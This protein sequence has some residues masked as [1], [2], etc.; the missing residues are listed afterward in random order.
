MRDLQARGARQDR[1]A[2]VQRAVVVLDRPARERAE[3][4]RAG[5]GRRDPAHHLARHDERHAEIAQQPIT[6]RAGAEDDVRGAIRVAIAAHRDA[7]FVGAPVDDRFA[8]VD[9]RAMS[10]RGRGERG[11]RVLRAQRAGVRLEE[12]H[13]IC[14][15]AKERKARLDLRRGR[16]TRGAAR[17]AAPRAATRRRTARSRGRGRDRR[18]CGT[19]RERSRARS[20]PRARR[21]GAAAA[22]SPLIGVRVEKL[23][24][25]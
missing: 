1:H 9:L 23:A 7:G 19:A 22:R 14:G 18:S 25:E 17:A 16:A 13:V 15:N 3:R 24:K 8:R 4:E 11:D 21:R 12:A 6:P 5:I 2:V 10:L 20:R